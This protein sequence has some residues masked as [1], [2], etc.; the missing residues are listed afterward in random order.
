MAPA[1]ESRSDHVRC[2][3]RVG[4]VL[5]DS[6]VL[7][8]RERGREGES[9]EPLVVSLLLVVRP[10]ALSRFLLLVAMPGAPSEEVHVCTLLR[11]QGEEAE[12]A[13]KGPKTHMT[14]AQPTL[15]T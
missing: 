7:L 4:L 14:C 8:L 12:N 5:R 1:L 6:A 10:G 2:S 13:L 3:A 15:T 11:C 9:Q